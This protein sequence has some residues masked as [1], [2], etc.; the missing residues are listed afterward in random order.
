MEPGLA[1]LALERAIT[2]GNSR[3]AVV[4]ADWPRFAG[5][6]AD[7]PRAR[8]L[9][10][11]LSGIAGVR[12]AAPG[13]ANPH[14][15]EEFGKRLRSLPPAE[16]EA[17]LLRVVRT[18]AAVVLGHDT[19]E[20]ISP[21]RGFVDMGFDSLTATR[22]RNRLA[23]ATGLHVSAATVF[24]HPTPNALTERLLEMYATPQARPRPA[25]RPRSR[26]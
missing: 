5:H 24:S 15:A 1:L 14:D 2:A 3:I 17:E 12:Q 9:A 13:A 22:L 11:V 20:A 6:L 7:D 25:L 8:P 18:H 10:R 23:T 19:A 16:R 21:E 26:S 4:D